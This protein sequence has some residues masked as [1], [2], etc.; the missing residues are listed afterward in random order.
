MTF[1]ALSQPSSFTGMSPWSWYIATTRSHFPAAASMKIVS[2]GNGPWTSMPVAF[3]MSIAG[4]ITRISSSP[5]SPFSPACGLRPHTAM[6]GFAIPSCWQIS[7]PSVIGSCTRPIVSRL[8]ISMS[9]TCVVASTTFS[10][11]EMNAIA[12][13]RALVRAANSSVCPGHRKPASVHDSFEIGAVTTASMRRGSLCARSA[14]WI[15][16]STKHFDASPPDF[17]G[18]R[19]L[20]SVPAMP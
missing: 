2:P 1:T 9:G 18:S 8:R 6:R 3:A 4:R 10:R 12:C 11:G 13:R 19:S 17:D 5:K 14:S 7:W 16:S 15:A 20:P